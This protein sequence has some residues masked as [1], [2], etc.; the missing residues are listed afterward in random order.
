MSPKGP[1]HK[2][3][4]SS[5]MLLTVGATFKQESSGWKLNYLGYALEGDCATS[6][7]LSLFLCPGHDENGST[8][9]MYFHKPKATEPMDHGMKPP[10]S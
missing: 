1:C 10:K 8:A 6:A 2:G 5:F 4:V 7:T 9:L 3:L